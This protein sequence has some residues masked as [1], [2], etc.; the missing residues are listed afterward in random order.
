MSWD[1]VPW[2]PSLC[3]CSLSPLVREQFE[4]LLDETRAL[5]G[6]AE[7][8]RASETS[9]GGP[10]T[11]G[12]KS[13]GSR[14]TSPLLK[15]RE[16][17]LRCLVSRCEGLWLWPGLVHWNKWAGQSLDLLGCE[18]QWGKRPNDSLSRRYKSPALST[19]APSGCH[20]LQHPCFR[21]VCALLQPCTQMCSWE[22]Y[23]ADTA[24]YEFL[25]KYQ[26][27]WSFS[28]LLEPHTSTFK[29]E[30]RYFQLRGAGLSAFLGGQEGEGK[31]SR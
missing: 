26:K 15:T 31:V 30:A 9:E 3:P 17:F 6:F 24:L 11:T 21:G 10:A 19:P 1:Q 13:R 8:H 5:W 28:G 29:E 27:A 18:T 22:A 16:V 4:H 25:L 23:E 14:E 7:L 20:M 12:R 2:Y